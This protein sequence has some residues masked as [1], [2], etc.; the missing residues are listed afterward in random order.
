MGR[1]VVIAVVVIAALFGYVAGRESMSS[2]MS[3][4]C[5]VLGSK[6]MGFNNLLDTVGDDE[7][8]HDGAAGGVVRTE[9]KQAVYDMRVVW[10]K[11]C[12]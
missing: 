11:Q 8:W 6:W 4:V 1:L 9:I 5:I 10:E 3:E 7:G 12:K 2:P